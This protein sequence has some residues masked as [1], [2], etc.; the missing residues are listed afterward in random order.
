[1]LQTRHIYLLPLVIAFFC[2]E[3]MTAQ[4]LL[5]NCQLEQIS[6]CPNNSGQIEKCKHYTSPG[7]GTPDYVHACN[8]GNYSVPN[9]IWGN[10]AAHSG[11][12]YVNII[13]YSFMSSN[14]EYREYFTG[15]LDCVMQAG[16]MYDISF[17]VSLADKSHYAI[18]GMG[19]HF[20]ETIPLQGDIN[21][22]G[23]INIGGPAHI[24]SP[25]GQPLNDKT[26]WQRIHGTY[27]A[28][29]GERFI[30][31]GNFKYNSE[32]TVET[33]PSWQSNIASYYIDDISVICMEPIFDLGPDTTICPGSSITF[34]VNNIC[35][36]A[37]LQWENGSTDL[38]RT[39]S[40]PGTYS[41]GGVIGCSNFYDDI[42]ISFPPDPGDILPPD[43]VICPNETIDILADTSFTSYLWQDGSTGK[44]YSTA[45][46]GDFRLTVKSQYG[47]YYTDSIHIMDLDDPFFY[48][49]P[50]TLFCLGR[51]ITLDP[52]IDSN[53]HQFLWN[54]NSLERIRTISDSGEYW[55]R[56]S[57]PCGVWTDTINIMTY[58]CDATFFAP[59][60]FTP[61]ND[62][63]NDTFMLKADNI[64][65][66][67]MFIYDRWGRLLYESTAHEKGWDGKY[68][69][70]LL[71]AGTYLWVA[72]YDE[73]PV[74]GEGENVKVSGAVMLLR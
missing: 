39:I 26:N 27:I 22:D 42:T 52:G 72:I 61:N 66:F 19:A 37:D 7:N 63:L 69:G 62:G 2:I 73:G 33:L 43:T 11:N 54:D 71:S 20:T 47:C 67:R 1:M 44:I 16:H 65:N 48:L 49:G 30:T 41:I 55:L 45:V 58:N 29:G 31:I 5:R 6:G 4:N 64:N 53:F 25:D 50:D 38:V 56:V 9:N 21:L 68:N 13:S 10:Q 51:S 14:R 23:M 60:A 57:N 15:I 34:D 46:A 18:D 12:G 36:T 24:S 28:Q 32:L 40:E 17:Y 8:T 3:S 70:Q 74:E 59:N 35:S